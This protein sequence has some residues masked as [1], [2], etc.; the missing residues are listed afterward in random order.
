[1]K[2]WLVLVLPAALL[3]CVTPA[4]RQQAVQV[5]P[6]AVP[7]AVGPVARRRISYDGA[8]N[9]I[10]PDGSVVPGD[11]SGGFTLPNGTY[12]TADGTGGVILPNGARCTSD[13]AGGYLCP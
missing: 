11:G 9:F 8:G 2:F 3:G 12:V 6:S 1:M 4:P 10:L 13:G 5:A 7:S